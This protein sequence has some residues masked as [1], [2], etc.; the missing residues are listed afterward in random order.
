MNPIA[1]II[2]KSTDYLYTFKSNLLIRNLEDTFIVIGKNTPWPDEEYIPEPPSNLSVIESPLVYKRVKRI[3][4]IYP[5]SCGTLYLEGKYWVRLGYIENITN[6]NNIPATKYVL[7]EA[8]IDWTDYLASGYRIFGLYTG[9]TLRPGINVNKEVYLPDEVQDP[10][11]LLS[12]S[13]SQE[14][15]RIE[16]KT[17]NFRIII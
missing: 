1:H 11:L 14:I 2:T 16:G 4:A 7:V 12:V 10:G 6:L 5:D 15:K 8:S 3:S 13:Y 17:H 9:L